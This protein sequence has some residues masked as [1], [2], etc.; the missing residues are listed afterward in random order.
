MKD[1]L[2]R[3]LITMD[4][5]AKL[6]QQYLKDPEGTA[7]A[8]GLSDEDVQLCAKNDVNAIKGRCEAE[9]ADNLE[10]SHSK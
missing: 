7:K 3:F 6:K 10:I 1:L 5:D 2:V 4:K 8:F 9:G